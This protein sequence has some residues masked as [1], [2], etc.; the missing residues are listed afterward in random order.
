[1]STERRQRL[2]PPCCHACGRPALGSPDTWAP[3]ADGS[4]WPSR[5]PHCAL[6]FAMDE[7]YDTLWHALERADGGAA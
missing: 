3:R 2:P 7:V 1:M 4:R 6:C 5:E